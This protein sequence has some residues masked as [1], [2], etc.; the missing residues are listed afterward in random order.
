MNVVHDKHKAYK[1]C[2]IGEYN[3]KR[4][5]DC[6]VDKA[7]VKRKFVYIGLMN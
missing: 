4:N 7:N 1:G 5:N 6:S 2:G 3:I